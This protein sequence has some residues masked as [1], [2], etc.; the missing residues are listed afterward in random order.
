M[1]ENA[2]KTSESLRISYE[3]EF[4]KSA[5]MTSANESLTIPHEILR[6]WL[7]LCRA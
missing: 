6:I 4:R 5:Y 7:M 3:N 1:A 2:C